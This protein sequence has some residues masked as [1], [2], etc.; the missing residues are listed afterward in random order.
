MLDGPID[1]LCQRISRHL[2]H[3]N[4]PRENGKPYLDR[5]Y[6]WRHFKQWP[7]VPGLY[8]H[9]FRAS[10]ELVL[11][12]HPFRWS[13]SLILC[14]GYFE[15]RLQSRFWDSATQRY[16]LKEVRRWLGQFRLN[17]IRAND[18]HRID[19]IDGSPTWTLFLAGPVI[20]SWEF[21]DRRDGFYYP[22]REYIQKR[23]HSRPLDSDG[24]PSKD[25]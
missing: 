13:I 18:Y 19:L 23:D 9:C 7:K 12:N 8:L 3:R 24:V 25:P 21:L 15:D 1:R 5:Y 22:W 4:I 2:S 20:Q 16:H 17:F 14:G 11:H 10:D 6:F